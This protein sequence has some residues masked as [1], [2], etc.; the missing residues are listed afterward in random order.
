M[1]EGGRMPYG[2]DLLKIIEAGMEGDREIRGL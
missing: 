1:N 2:S